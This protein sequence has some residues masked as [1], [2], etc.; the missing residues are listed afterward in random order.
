MDNGVPVTNLQAS[1]GQQKEYFIDVNAGNTLKVTLN[2]GSGDADL[3]VRHG[4]KP[5]TSQWDCRPYRYG[6]NEVCTISNTQAGR[7]HI[8]LNAYSAYNGA[9]L[10]ASY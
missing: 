10:V 5:T 2:G 4:A 1:R 9:T 6:N 7:Y 8:M 3:Y